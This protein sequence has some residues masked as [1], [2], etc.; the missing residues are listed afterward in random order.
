MGETECLRLYPKSDVSLDGS[1]QFTSRSLGCS[2]RCFAPGDVHRLLMVWD[3]RVLIIIWN[4]IIQLAFA[5][6]ILLTPC[7]A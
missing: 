2:V 5:G 6:D 3:A 1:R 4:P 7:V